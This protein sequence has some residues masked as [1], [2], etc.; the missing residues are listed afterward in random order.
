[1]NDQDLHEHIEALVKQEHALY[2]K[3]NLSDAEQSELGNLK[4]KLDQVWDLLRQ[5]RAKEE[6][7]QNPDEAQER[8][9][10]TV[11]GYTNTPY[12]EKH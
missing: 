11:E 3:G 9:V 10:T 5:R 7:S 4:V 12:R 1:M 2:D 6:Y 8:S